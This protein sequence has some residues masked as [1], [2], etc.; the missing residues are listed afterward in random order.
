MDKLGLIEVFIEV[1]NTGNFVN[2]A[3]SLGLSPSTVSKA[4]ARLE[5]H[6]KFKLFNRST[7]QLKLTPE[8]LI[9][10][11]IARNMLAELNEC[12]NQLRCDRQRPQGSLKINSSISYGRLYLLPIIKEFRSRYSDI[13]IDITFSDRYVDVIEHGVDVCIRSGQLSESSLIGR[14]LSPI[15]FLICASPDYIERY[16]YPISVEELSNHSWI[17]F[18]FKQTGRIM[19]IRIKHGNEE[20]QVDPNRDFIVDD[21]EALASLCAD[22]LGI[23]QL[24]HFIARDWI[25]K[26]KIVLLFPTERPK[27]FGIYAVYASQKS[28]SAKISVFVEFLHQHLYSQGESTFY[29]WAEQLTPLMDRLR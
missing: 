2:T 28:T 12:E 11:E 9:Y 15:D 19:P 6:L 17:R 1:V 25:Q 23:T 5:S 24:P 26:K 13:N 29:T 4:V 21:G 27:G 22:G 16:G 10:S 20:K 14:Q 3:G 8:G 7:R 18:R